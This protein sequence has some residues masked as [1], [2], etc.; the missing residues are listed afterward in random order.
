MTPNTFPMPNTLPIIAWARRLASASLLALVTLSGCTA[1]PDF[2]RPKAVQGAAYLREGLP[3]TLATTPAPGGKAQRLAEGKDVPGDWWALFGSPTLNAL[4]EEALKANPNVAAAQAALRQAREMAHADQGG[5]FPTVGASVSQSRQRSS[6]AG[7]GRAGSAQV[8]SLS[9]A[10]LS[11]SYAPDMFGGTRRR[12]ESAEA[13]AEYQRFQLEATYLTLT[14]NVVNTAVTLASIQ[15]QIAATGD[16]LKTQQQQ[17]AVLHAQLRFGAIANTEILAQQ[18]AIEQ[19]KASLPP[20]QKQLAQARNQLMALVGR[21]PNQDKGETFT[22]ATLNLPLE[23]PV[24]LPSRLIDQ[25][26]DV[27]SAEAQLHS[28]S[29]GIGVATAAQLPQF[30]ITGQLGI[31]AA[32]L[33]QMFAPGIAIW[34][35][36]GSVAQSLFDG[37]AAEH[38]KRGAV[39]AYD[40]AAAGYRATVLAAFQDV[41]NA[42]RALQ[43]DGLAL[44]AQADAERTARQSLDLAMRQYRL[45]AVSQLTVL[46]AQQ[47]WENAVL[48]R[49]RAQAARY[50]DTA[51]LFQA[52]GGGWWNRT[53]VDP[54]S[55]G[56]PDRFT[57]P[58]FDK[59]HLRRR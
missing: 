10:S 15:D 20:L 52:L 12:I 14:A 31:S 6:T 51:A 59:V 29:A 22:L 48:A 57:L 39:A 44:K 17:S 41:A 2:S 47:T 5:L 25:R 30:T 21:F 9:T 8:F 33:D 36:A 54:Q 32:S 7:T 19:T 37:G 56:Q 49:V 42:L 13:E 1:G 11:V 35:I 45:G 43:S 3:A 53:D 55:M 46:S 40:E 23:L 27:R 58:P 4:V 38:R 18:T 50:S 24:S 26:P 28:A 34:N 16:I